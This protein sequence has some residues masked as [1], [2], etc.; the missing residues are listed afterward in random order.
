MYKLVNKIQEKY[1]RN[2][3]QL[4]KIPRYPG[5]KAD[6]EDFWLL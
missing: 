2:L 3:T 5:F 4:S 1:F 6:P